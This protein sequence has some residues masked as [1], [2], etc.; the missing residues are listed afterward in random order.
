MGR[1]LQN[2]LLKVR[3]SKSLRKAVGLYVVLLLYCAAAVSM[4][5]AGRDGIRVPF[6]VSCHIAPWAYWIFA[7]FSALLLGGEYDGKLCRNA[8]SCGVS[9]ERYY[10]A[11]VLATYIASFSLYVAAVV[12]V[13]VIGT[14]RFGFNPKG[15][16][17][18]NY[19]LKVFAFNGMGLAV[20]FA[21]VSIFNLLCF[22]FRSSGLPFI[23]GVLISFRDMLSTAM[24]VKYYG[25]LK[26]LPKNLYTVNE[27]MKKESKTLDILTPEFLG[28]YVP[29]LCVGG[30]AL[31]A[32][33]VLFKVRDVE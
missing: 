5:K 21:Y 23:L 22:G 16:I 26:E 11:K 4:T 29:C 2:E 10:G 19:W 24:T 3:R 30:A 32:G 13:T 7:A 12:L 14:V 25:Y 1:M 31:I 15:L 28:M 27:L 9:R 17:I 20:I 33:Y 8:I 18:E 6:W